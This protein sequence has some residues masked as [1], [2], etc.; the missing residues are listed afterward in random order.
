MTATTFSRLSSDATP[1]AMLRPLFLCSLLG[2]TL[3]G[4]AASQDQSEAAA[5]GDAAVDPSPQPV[6]Q[7]DPFELPAWSR[8]M[9]PVRLEVA[10]VPGL[11]DDAML[12]RIGQRLAVSLGPACDLTVARVARPTAD[13]F[14]EP[15]DDADPVPDDLGKRITLRIDR[16]AVSGH[17][18]DLW[19][20]S[21]GPI[22]TE[23][24]PPQGLRATAIADLAARL[25]RPRLLLVIDGATIRS[26]PWGHAFDRAI[27]RRGDLA[28]PLLRFET[29]D[30]T[31]RDTRPINWTLLEV[32]DP[33]DA[34]SL[35]VGLEMI[36]GFRAPIPERVRRGEPMAL[37]ERPLF[38]RTELVLMTGGQPTAGLEMQATLPGQLPEGEEREFGQVIPPK[39][40]ATARSDRFGRVSLPRAGLPPWVWVDVASE[41]VLARVPVGVGLRDRIEVPLT[42]DAIDIALTERMNAIRADLTDA[43]ASRVVLLARARKAMKNQ[44][45]ALVEESFKEIDDLP[46]AEEFLNELNTARVEAAEAA[47]N[48]R[49]TAARARLM[50]ERLGRTVSESLDDQVVD[51]LREE[52][53][54]LRQGGEK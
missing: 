46:D 23:P 38:D 7:R 18:T 42:D 24:L 51:D 17:E 32:T 4:P 50:T 37:V 29:R 28:R 48:D 19:V 8:R 26:E 34:E 10:A 27:V 33:G 20:Q 47:G 52:A 16:E 15:D 36:S 22:A 31:F 12:D 25:F 14:P 35:D 53:A 45:W 49:R 21:V 30:R 40:F 39:V 13:A 41:T 43:F 44:E 9:Y 54:L 3:A 1:A 2:L 11:I 6:A 5:V